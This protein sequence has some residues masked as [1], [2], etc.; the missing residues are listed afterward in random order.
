MITCIASRGYISDLPPSTPNRLLWAGAAIGIRENTD[1]SF[2][3]APPGRPSPSPP[4]PWSPGQ[5]LNECSYHGDGEC[6]DGGPGAHYGICPYATDC[7]DCGSRPHLPPAAPSPPPL[8]PPPPIWPGR[9]VCADTCAYA[10][11]SDCD[12]GGPGAEFEIC[13][14]ASD[15]ADCGSRVAIDPP[16]PLSPGAFH[17][18]SPTPPPPLAP[19]EYDCND[20]CLYTSD[21]DCDDGGPGSEYSLCE[22][23][24]DCSDCAPRPLVHPSP[25]PPPPFDA[26]R[27][28]IGLG[29]KIAQAFVP[30]GGVAPA[31]VGG[32]PLRFPRQYPW[33]VSLQTASSRGH[34]CG[35]TLIH[36]RWVLTAAHCTSGRAAADIAVAVGAHDLYADDDGCVQRRSVA[37][38]LR[39]PDAAGVAH[40]V[41]LLMLDTP[42]T[43]YSPIPGLDDGRASGV[44]QML[45]VAGWGATSSGGMLPWLAHHVRVPVVGRE[46]C[47]SSY[48]R[49]IL[50]GMLCAGNE[51]GG[52]DACQGD[53]GGPLFG[54]PVGDGPS[55]PMVLVGVVSWGLGCAEAGFPGVY[56]RV[57]AYVPWIR[58]TAG[59]VPPPAPPLPPAPPSL[60]PLAPSPPHSPGPPHSPLKPPPHPSPSPSPPPA[61]PPSPCRPWCAGHPRPWDY[62]C[63]LFPSCGHCIECHVSPP[64]A[65][66]SRTYPPPAPPTTPS[67]QPCIPPLPPSPLSP[68]PPPAPLAPTLG[69]SCVLRPEHLGLECS[70][71]YVWSRR[72]SVPVGQALRCR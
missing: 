62:K 70:C 14:Y 28:L 59:L 31:I 26:G 27:C 66:S 34:F 58:S 48:P 20:S 53:S 72:S 22:H 6:D 3:P 38:I 46:S 42:V 37:A 43:D 32:G 13:P 12:D 4:P 15:C 35:G 23:G 5:C 30:A 61:T 51:R 36:P 24:T 71:R 63:S 7:A 18:P 17:S 44:G 19:G 67:P 52:Q 10:S 54:A 56:T 68:P 25:P 8:P 16:A 33:L 39:H 47:A 57:S 65:L 9:E 55:A 45:T 49:D 11:D 41:A 50:E 21:G 29:T 60:L 1:C 40:D 2:P 64:P 69:T